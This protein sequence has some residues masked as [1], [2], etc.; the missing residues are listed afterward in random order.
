M[1]QVSSIAVGFDGSVESETALRWAAG[2]ARESEATLTVIHAAGILGRL[3]ATF[4][5]EVVPESVQ[6]I[7]SEEGVDATRY[8]WTIQEGDACSALLASASP[9][10]NAQ[11]LVVGSRGHGK[12]PGT[13]IGSVSLEVVQHAKVPVVVVPGS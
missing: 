10:V 9:P 13:M 4:V 3:D 11:M 12:R 1:K 6:R 2:M 7:M 8:H 5:P